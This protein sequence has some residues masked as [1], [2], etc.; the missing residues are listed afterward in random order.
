MNRQRRPSSSGRSAALPAVCF[1][2]GLAIGRWLW[3]C[4]Q[5]ERR[6]VQSSRQIVQQAH[7]A[8]ISANAAN[9]ITMANP[10]A[11]DLF[12]TSV[13]D[14][15]GSRIDRYI[16]GRDGSSAEPFRFFHAGDGRAGRRATD[17]AVTG[18]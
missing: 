1:L 6:T 12:G 2:L 15:V 7:E 9:I 13:E 14:M 4:M 5:Q 10:A 3:R 11:A 18:L 17:Y 8:I 16:E